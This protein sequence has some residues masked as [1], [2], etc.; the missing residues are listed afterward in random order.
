MSPFQASSRRRNSMTRV[1]F[2]LERRSHASAPASSP[3]IITHLPIDNEFTRL[4]DRMRRR[5]VAGGSQ[6]SSNF[7]LNSIFGA[8]SAVTSSFLRRFAARP[9]V[10]VTDCQLRMCERILGVDYGL[11]AVAV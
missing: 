10:F 4:I 2:D 11:D 8:Y 7:G 9:I 1:I 3:S 6:K 5:F